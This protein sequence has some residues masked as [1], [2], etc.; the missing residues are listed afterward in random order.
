MGASISWTEMHPSPPRLG[1]RGRLLASPKPHPQAAAAPAVWMCPGVQLGRDDCCEAGSVRHCAPQGRQRDTGFG[2]VLHH[3]SLRKALP[4]SNGTANEHWFFFPT[5]YFPENKCREF[6]STRAGGGE[7]RH[8]GTASVLWGAARWRWS[9]GRGWWAT[10]FSLR[11]SGKGPPGGQPASSLSSARPVPTAARALITSL[12]IKLPVISLLFQNS[13]PLKAKASHV[14]C[15]A[16]SAPGTVPGL[17]WINSPRPHCDPL[18]QWWGIPT[19]QMKDPNRGDVYP[20]TGKAGSF[21]Y[22]RFCG[23]VSKQCSTWVI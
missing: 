8:R 6:L 18:G 9:Q 22:L 17:L 4:K 21:E 14:Y 13:N 11:G 10:S 19:F 20:S 16:H 3:F 23:R 15:Q 5:G 7:Q 12:A 2:S 1:P